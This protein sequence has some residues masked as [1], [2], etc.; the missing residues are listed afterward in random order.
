MTRLNTSAMDGWPGI[1]YLRIRA[2]LQYINGRPRGSGVAELPAGVLA[3]DVF[4]CRR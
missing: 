1:Y 4:H 2:N 3:R